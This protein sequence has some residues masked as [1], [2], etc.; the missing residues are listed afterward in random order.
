MEFAQNKGLPVKILGEKL[1]Q[2]N[3]YFNFG[4]NLKDH[5]IGNYYEPDFKDLARVMRNAFENYTDHKKRAVEVAKLIHSD[6]NWD[7]SS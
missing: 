7:R 6:F 3:T 4:I 2:G 1:T 5:H